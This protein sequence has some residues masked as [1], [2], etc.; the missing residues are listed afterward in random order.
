MS[1]SNPNVTIT[2]NGN[3]SDQ[4]FGIN[5]HYLEGVTTVIQVEL[6]N[7][8]NPEVPVKES[9]VLGVDYTIDESNYPNTL[10]NTTDPVAVDY[11]LIIYRSTVPVQTTNFVNGAFP[12][13]SV[14]ESIDKVMM[15]TQEQYEK[16]DRAILN[17][18]GGPE[19]DVLQLLQA[20][21]DIQ[22]NADNI[23]TNATNIGTNASAIG[24][25]TSAIGANTSAIGT[26]AS[27]IATL[28]SQVALIAAEVLVPITV[29]SSTHNASLLEIVLV[30]SANVTV[31]LPAPV[32]SGQIKVK[33]DGL[34]VGC[35]VNSA[36][37]IDGFGTSYTLQSEYESI[38]LVSD[39]TKWYII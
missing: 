10:V 28:Q 9:F 21:E 35:V 14:E 17:P 37:G 23:S 4:S 7:Y 1:Y 16:L 33:M 8:T 22:T 11:K 38:S 15:A 30:Q 5:F 12:A 20:L 18:I 13:E 36:A 31:E 34:L 27:A 26:N 3:G 2:Y 6:W 19:L 39:G 29:A 32:L 24:A 25:N